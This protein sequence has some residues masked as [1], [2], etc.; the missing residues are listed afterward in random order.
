MAPGV[1][2][3]LHASAW[4]PPG[5]SQNPHQAAANQ[6]YRRPE[7]ALADHPA[8]AH[9]RQPTS[10][11]ESPASGLGTK[12]AGLM[13]GASIPLRRE[14]AERDVLQ[15]ITQH[16]PATPERLDEIPAV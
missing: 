10:R 6:R 4:I 13:V 5:K 16:M 1:D 9:K 3:K 7:T 11:K 15:G 8:A 12:G 2:R 14:F